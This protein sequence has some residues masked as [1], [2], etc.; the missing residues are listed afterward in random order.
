[1][2]GRF[3]LTAEAK[4]LA[5]R[6][7]VEISA[8]FYKVIKPRYNIAPTQSVIVVGDDGGRC[9]KQMVWGLIPSWAKDPAIGNKMINARAETLTIRPAYRVPLRKRRCLI[10]ADGFYEWKKEGNLKQPM[11]IVLKNRE[12][13][14]F[15]GLWETWKAP[16]GGEIVSCVIITTEANELVGTIHDRM[17]VILPRK[18]EDRWLDPASEVAEVLRLLKPYPASEME[19]YPVSRI[20]NAPVHDAPDCIALI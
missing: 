18:A 6:F 5:K 17:P 16:D 2:C 10:M 19:L 1:M 15:A 9:V 8:S 13:F 4:E 3:T 7:G 14:G 20:V 12:P 11:R